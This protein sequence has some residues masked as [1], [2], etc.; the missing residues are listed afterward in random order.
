[1]AK[2]L[3]AHEQPVQKIFSDEYVFR[4]PD[5]QRP[6][7]W[8]P[9]QARELLDDLLGFTQANPGPVIDM[10]TYFL[11]SIVLIKGDSPDSDVVD[12]QQRL[13]TLTLL[14]AAIRANVDQKLQSLI[15]KRLYEQGDTFTG[16]EDRFRLTLRERDA[17]FFKKYVQLEGGFP[18]LLKLEASLVDS[19]LNLR[20]NAR[21]FQEKLEKMKEEMRVELAQFILQR[22]YLV[23]VAT[24]D[25]NSA[26]R[27][28]SVL[29]SRGLDLTA[30]DILKARII[31]GIAESNR[32]RYTAKWEDAE[33]DLGRDDFNTLFGHIRTI[34]R[35]AKA[36][37]TLLKEFEE[38]VPAI[39]TP[40]KFI[41]DVL[42]PMAQAYGD[43]SSSSYSAP[44][45]AEI[46][47]G[48]LRWLNRLEFNDW[49]PPAIAFAVAH[50]DN[51]PAMAE[52]LSDLERLAYYMLVTSKNVND[53][54]ERFAK[55]TGE[56]EARKD[57]SLE[58]SS[59]QLEPPEQMD[60]HQRLDG[61]IYEDLS[62]KART[63]VL[64]RL[65]SLLSGG[66]A[67]YDYSVI[68]VEHVLPQNPKVGSKW[69]EWF[70]DPVNRA[71]IVHRIGNLALLTRK[72]NGQAS[73]WDF[74]RKKDSYFR[75][76]G[77]SPFV[78]TTQV[79]NTL[80]WSPEV[81]EQRQK[82]LIQLLDAHWRLE[83][84][85]SEADWLVENL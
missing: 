32:E 12:G 35:K 40:I 69:L 9:D 1:M 79:L 66:G 68:S 63:P 58:T 19:R 59:L 45:H 72:K 5:Y 52:F 14:L 56:I 13:T 27:I 65:D 61:P 25:E 77:I 29:N 46:V 2:T 43:L 17:E 26:Y 42:L 64:L 73:N 38:Y 70:P 50:R 82:A 83:K 51:A 60:F 18:E 34:F 28:F 67:N 48:H 20:N 78:L 30:T 36:K 7:S 55:V 54:I 75:R 85:K 15:T 10:P 39:R 84:R 49:V 3:V 76:E 47:N 81:V 74:D 11:G 37:E 24:P 21:L 62:A 44:S 41:D 53:R 71:R 31:G 33:E 8:T 23:V 16:T 4:I 22:C 80:E 57:L 6:Y